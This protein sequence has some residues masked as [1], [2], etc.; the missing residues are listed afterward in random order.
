AEQPRA[1]ADDR[2]HSDLP[3]DGDDLSQFLELFDHHDD[4]LAQLDAEERHADETGILV[5]VEDDQ[6]A[7]LILEREAG[8]QF[9][10]AANFEAELVRLARFE[11][12]LHHFAKLVDL[13]REYPPVL[14]LVI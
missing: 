11:D 1:D 2:F 5:A 6:T 13:D 10:L 8:K 14:T 12:F 9:R 4:L 7:R 3:G